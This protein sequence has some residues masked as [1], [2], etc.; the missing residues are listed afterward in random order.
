MNV[1][2]VDDDPIVVESLA[3]ILDAQPDIEIAGTAT[4][5]PGAEAR[6]AELNP[7]VVLMDV[8]MPKGD[9]LTSGKAIITSDPTARVVYLTTFADDDYIVQALRLG[10]RGYLIKQEARAIAPALRK[11]MTGEIV[12]AGE[13]AELAQSTSD[14]PGAMTSSAPMGP[15]TRLTDRERVVIDLIAEGLDNKEIASELHLSEGTVR[16]HISMILAKL[17]LKNRT[18]VAVWAWRRKSLAKNGT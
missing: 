13:V 6:Y 16:N 14:S 2:I 1:L 10:A 15:P 9:G 7:D 17:G 3:T 5:G 8:R 4:S 18:Q 11:V 12:L